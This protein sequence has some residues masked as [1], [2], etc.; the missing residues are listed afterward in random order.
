MLYFCIPPNDQMLEYWDRIADRLFKIRHCQN[1]DGVERSLALFA[2]PID[3]GMLV[4]AAA[5]GLDISDVVAGVN[6]PVP[7]YRFTIFAQKA[8]ELAA[9]VASLG[10]ELQQTLERRD[11]EAMSLLHG[12][13]ELKSLNS[14]RDTRLLHIQEAQ[15]QIETLKASKA[16]VDERNAYYTNIEKIIAKEQFNLDKL[17]ESHDYQMASQIVQATAAVLALI[18]DF[19]IGASGF[20]GSPHAAAKWGGTFLAHSA[21]AASSVLTVLSTAASYEA[22]RASILGGYDRRFDDW[23]LQERVAKKELAQLDKQ[24]TAAE[25]R[26]ESVQSELKNHD[27]QIENSKKSSDF[28]RSK[29]TNQELYDW[30]VGRISAVYFQS[31]QLAHEFAKKAERCYR[32]ELGNDDFFISYGYWRPPRVWCT[33]SSACS[34]PIWRGTGASTRSPS[35]SPWLSWTRSRWLG[36]GRRRRRTSRCPRCCTTWTI[37]GTTSAG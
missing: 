27:L 23:K 31:Y 5:A 33:T 19:A 37:P 3:P 20:G 26:L 32:F 15:A 1:I 2:P 14:M 9:E 29:F 35:R 10:L 30:M 22:N 28:M 6:A 17:S 34:P 7:C 18:P 36:C 8:A 21:T 12:E 25:L 4:R 24:L 11:N 13:L 16:I